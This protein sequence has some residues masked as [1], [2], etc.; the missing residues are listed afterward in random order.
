MD[1]SQNKKDLNAEW[2][3]TA[4]LEQR[5]REMES[6]MAAGMTPK[7]LFLEST[8]ESLPSYATTGSCRVKG[9]QLETGCVP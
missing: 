6:A 7:P 5:L 3:K 9:L 1:F 4:I 2:K 8:I